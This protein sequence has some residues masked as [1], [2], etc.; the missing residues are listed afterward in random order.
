VRH[1]GGIQ[2]GAGT[3]QGAR[4]LVQ[5]GAGQGAGGGAVADAHF[6]AD[7][8]FASGLLGAQHAVASRLQGR[9]GLLRTHRRAAGQVL[10]AGADLQQ[11]HARQRRRRH[12]AAEVDHLQAGAQLPRQHADRRAAADEVG[13]H[14]PGDRLRESRHPFGDHA[15]V[16][17]EN[18]DPQPFDARPFTALQAGQ[19]D[20]QLLQLTE[21]AGRLGQ[22]LLTRHGLGPHLL[23]HRLGAGQPPWMLHNPSPFK[24]IGNPATVKTTR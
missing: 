5:Q 17:G 12:C 23:I 20:R 21:R 3:D 22:L 7:K 2:P 19:L 8:Q 6:A 9:A 11:A 16:A 13:Q 1:P 15:M 24:T 10:R 4:R 18:A 14:L